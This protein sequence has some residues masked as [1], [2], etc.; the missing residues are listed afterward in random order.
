MMVYF[1]RLKG[2][3]KARAKAK[4]QDYL[5]RVDLADNA[6]GRTAHRRHPSDLWFGAAVPGVGVPA[7]Q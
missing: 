4:S 1:F 5:E 7:G 2:L 6:G 3:D